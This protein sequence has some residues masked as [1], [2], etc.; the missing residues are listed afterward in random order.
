M[1]LKKQPIVKKLTKISKTKKKI[2]TIGKFSGI[3]SPLPPFPSHLE[4]LKE[5]C[6]KIAKQLDE[7]L[8]ALD[9]HQKTKY[10]DVQDM[11]DH[12]YN[13]NINMDRML[14]LVIRL[15]H[16]MQHTSATF[17]EMEKIKETV[18][19]VDDDFKKH[20]PKLEYI[21]Q[22]VQAHTQSEE[23]AKRIYG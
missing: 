4:P 9:E 11:W 10:F 6:L 22:Q 19:K 12:V 1:A 15:F 16:E 13:A 8:S 2:Q 18:Q 7:E 3:P 23:R 5:L 20:K 14:Y 17:E 21:D